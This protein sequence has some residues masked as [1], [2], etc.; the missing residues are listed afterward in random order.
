M[1]S[2]L[3]IGWLWTFFVSVVVFRVLVGVQNAR[4]A[5]SD[6]AHIAA[7]SGTDPSLAAVI[8]FFFGITAPYFLY[9][10]RGWRGLLMGIALVVVAI[11]GSLATN[12][13]LAV[14]GR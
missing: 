9:V 1:V 3:L 13:A 7:T 10:A 11:G 8:T 6:D 2:S 14:A 12:V 5:A 4:I